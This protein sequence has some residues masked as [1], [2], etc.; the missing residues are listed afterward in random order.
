M[1]MK[2]MIDFVIPCHPKDFPSLK[3]ASEGIKNI[4]CANRVF[5]VSI[6][7]P[8]LDGVIHISE[9]RYDKYINKEKIAKNFSTYAPHLLYRTKW[10]YQQFLKLYAFEVI[11]ELTDSYVLVDSDIIFLRDVQFDIEKFYYCKAE[12]YHKPYLKPIKKLLG[13]EE[14]IGFST[15]CHHM[16]FNKEKM[17]EMHSFIKDKFNSDSLFDTILSILDY[18][19]SSC[20]SEWDLYSN[21]MIL[22]YPEMCQHRQLKWT[23]SFIGES[24]NINNGIHFIPDNSHLEEFKDNFD[25]AS[26]HAY[27]RGIE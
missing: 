6:E 14:T 1:Q 24:R 3:M 8:K 11:P 25:F 18:T 7:N 5:V 21:Y 20:I 16:I 19:E 9:E 2:N 4:S 23:E 12:E 27:R 13:V 22:N 10:V 15:I 17:A 26:C